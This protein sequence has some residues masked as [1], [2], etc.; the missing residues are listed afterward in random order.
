MLNEQT[1]QKNPIFI[2]LLFLSRK[3]YLAQG[4][5]TIFLNHQK[6]LK[7]FLEVKAIFQ[8]VFVLER[9]F[10]LRVISKADN[11]HDIFALFLRFFTTTNFTCISCAVFAPLWQMGLNCSYVNKVRLDVILLQ[12]WMAPFTS[13]TMCFPICPLC[14]RFGEI[15]PCIPN[16]KA[17][18]G[19]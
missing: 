14:I 17:C 19:V 15:N 4:T 5:T 7:I 10:V 2:L 13:N 12:N 8:E 9:S 1:N 18:K 3:F 6:E 11:I 16:R